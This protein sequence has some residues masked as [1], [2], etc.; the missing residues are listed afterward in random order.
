MHNHLLL[1]VITPE[2]TVFSDEVSECTFPTAHSGYYGILPGHTPLV[3]PVGDGLITFTRDNQKEV[4]TVFGGFAEVGPEK[5]SILARASESPAT[6]NAAALEQARD[7]A[8]RALKEAKEPESMTS[9][10][11]AL[12]AARIRLQALGKDS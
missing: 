8:Q 4:L 12:D 3:T 5:I 9:A 10:R 11:K 2:K 6:L 7:E 1:E